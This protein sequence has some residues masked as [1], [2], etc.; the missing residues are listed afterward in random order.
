MV[1][2]TNASLNQS[3]MTVNAQYILNF[4]LGKGWSKNAICAMLGNMQTESTINFGIYESLDNTS[5]TNGFGLVQWTPNTKYFN[6]ANANGYSNDHVN[7]ELNRLLY[8]VA[9][10]IQWIPD[11]HYQ[12]YG[13]SHAYNYSFSAFITSTDTPENLADAWL[14][15]YE[16]AAN[17]DQ[18]IRATQARSW[19]DSLTGNGGGSGGVTPTNDD[20]MYLILSGALPNLQ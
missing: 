4:F 8:E 16:G 15:N 19:Y 18:P 2:D 17:P 1:Y 9:N 6:W 14:W 5:S 10:S 3:E 7:G 13:L 11:G 20:L 12:R